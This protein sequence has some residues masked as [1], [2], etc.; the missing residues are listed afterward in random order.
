MQ[1]SGTR[2]RRTTLPFGTYERRRNT[3]LHLA[4]GAICLLCCG[5]VG[6]YAAN[7]RRRNAESESPLLNTECGEKGSPF[8]QVV[9]Y[10]D[11]VAAHSNCND[12]VISYGFARFRPNGE[13]CSSSDENGVVTLTPIGERL[14]GRWDLFRQ[15]KRASGGGGK[16]DGESPANDESEVANNNKESEKSDSDKE[17]EKKEEEEEYICGVQTGMLWQCVEFARRYWFLTQRAIFGSVDGAEDIFKLRTADV[18]ADDVDGGGT[19]LYQRHLD[20]HKNHETAVRPAKGDQLIWRRQTDMPYGHVGIVSGIV[21]LPGSGFEHSQRAEQRS[22]VAEGGA[23]L[24]GDDPSSVAAAY[25]DPHSDGGQL[26]GGFHGAVAAAA[27]MGMN[28]HNLNS[29][30]GSH[31]PGSNG[32]DA[33]GGSGG[34]EMGG[35]YDYEKRRAALVRAKLALDVEEGFVK[36]AKLVYAERAR[37]AEGDGSGKESRSRRE[38]MP[39]PVDEAAVRAEARRFLR[40]HVPI[41]TVGVADQNYHSVQW[42]HKRGFHRYLVLLKDDTHAEGE[43]FVLVD[44]EGYAVLGWVRLGERVPLEPPK[45]GV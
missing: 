35:E 30:G 11:G 42:G 2:P 33:G 25:V 22:G 16:G 38:R 34:Y 31:T 20:T 26:G 36:G 14:K 37:A 44:P 21:F 43:R 28:V 29:Y 17:K 15:R 10:L 27:A 19:V 24:L 40:G 13:L 18:L 5:A 1:G 45:E 32:G 23:H 41:G 9:G 7:V 6:I 8:G 39:P 12:K 4:I 3:S